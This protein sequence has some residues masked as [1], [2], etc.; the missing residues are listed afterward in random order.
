M[1][2]F[3]STKN[4]KSGTPAHLVGSVRRRPLYH[5]TQPNVY[6]YVIEM[7]PGNVLQVTAPV[8]RY[9]NKLQNLFFML[10]S[11]GL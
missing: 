9:F 1:N 2:F 11:V 3:P 7:E 8:R 6:T 5:G 10:T 4:E